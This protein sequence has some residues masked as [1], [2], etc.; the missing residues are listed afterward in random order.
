MFESILIILIGF[1]VIAIFDILSSILSRA[2]NFEYVWFAFGS[3]IIYG[4]IA[5]YLN[6][7]GTFVTAIIGSFIAGAFD[8]TVGI[9]I[10]RVFKAKI[11]EQ[12]Q[13]I[14][15]ISPKL[16]LHMGILAS[17]IGAMTIVVFK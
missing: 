2:F 14:I 12:D 3:F 11:L 17:I 16:V 15:K 9:I 4:L 5:L 6:S 7:Y 10:A 8:S 13:E 1:S